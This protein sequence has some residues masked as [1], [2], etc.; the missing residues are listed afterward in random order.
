MLSGRRGFKQG[1]KY[2]PDIVQDAGLGGGIG[3]EVVSLHE[4][5]VVSD[6]GE[7][8]SDQGHPFLLGN[9]LEDGLKAVGISRTVVGRQAQPHEQD[10]TAAGASGPDHLLKVVAD[11]PEAESAQAIIGTEANDQKVRLMLGQQAGQA[12]ASTRGGLAR[13]AGVD[14][15]LWQSALTQALLEQEHPALLPVQA[16]ASA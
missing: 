11:N 9:L 7:E 6:T 10:L 4:V 3:V 14:Q 12:G 1:P 13:N 5:A 8:V 16:I 15:A 2:R